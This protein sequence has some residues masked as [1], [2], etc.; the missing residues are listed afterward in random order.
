[1]KKIKMFAL[2][3]L[4][5]CTGLLGTACKGSDNS[6]KTAEAA[7]TSKASGIDKK[8][9]KVGLILSGSISDKSWN[10][11]AYQG[12]QLIEKE[13]AEVFYQENVAI[14]DCADSIRTYAE[15]GMNLIYISSDSYQD[16]VAENASNYPDVTFIIINGTEQ[17]T[18]YYSVQISDEEQGFLLGVIAAYASDAKKAGFVGGMEI[19]PIINGNK[20]FE[21]GVKYVNPEIEID[22]A[23]TGDFLDVTAAKEQ[24]VAFADAGVDVVV[25]MADDASIGVIEGAQASGIYSVGT[26]DGQKGKGPDTMLTAVNKDTSVAYLA[27]YK[28]FLD[29]KLSGDSI[30]KYGAKEGVVYL[31][32]WLPASDQIL[33]DDDKEKIADVFKKLESKEI[34]VSIDQS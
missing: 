32:E 8:G 4:L 12:L 1:M 21:Q 30:P 5:V 15:A 23:M 25:P 22:S 2:S 13:G 27:S 29:G 3:V 14:S 19:T 31:G 11:T 17:G 34:S 24:T 16:V 33:S 10:Y 7:G 6:S 28:P 20:G 18:N 9:Q 26:G